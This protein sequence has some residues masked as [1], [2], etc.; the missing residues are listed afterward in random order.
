MLLNK[1]L[2]FVTL[3]DKGLRQSNADAVFGGENLFIVADG[4]GTASGSDLASQMAVDVVQQCFFTQIDLLSAIRQ[5][6]VNLRQYSVKNSHLSSFGTTI[7]AAAYSE[8]NCHIAWV[9]DSRA[10]LI[11]LNKQSIELLTHDHSL[12][13]RLVEN[14]DITY[15]QSRTHP[16]R[17][18][19]TRCLGLTQQ[20][21]IEVDS[22][23]FQWRDSQILLLCSD[24]LSGSLRDEKILQCLQQLKSQQ[25]LADEL[26][27]MALQAGS[28][29]NISLVLVA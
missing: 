6:H 22:V 9:G 8:G 11:D 24:G 14:G 7:V 12:V 26:L 1:P 4:V 3:T 25:E 17:N 13:N 19:I 5:A 28:K 15:D 23:V 29:D 27:L 16:Q 21:N 2:A 10:Y 18:V 20:E